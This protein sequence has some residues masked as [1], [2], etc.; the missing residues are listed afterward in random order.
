MESSSFISGIKITSET[1]IMTAGIIANNF[2]FEDG[3]FCDISY[4]IRFKVI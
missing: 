2:L 1:K 4:D 3:L